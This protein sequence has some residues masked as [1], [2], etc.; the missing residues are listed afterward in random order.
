MPKVASNHGSR[1]RRYKGERFA[2]PAPTI[3]APPKN[4]WHCP[5]CPRSF[6]DE[7]YGA[8]HLSEWHGY[9]FGDEANFD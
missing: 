7:Y 1:K 3:E 9:D 2:K 8:D 4:T 5:H 6:V